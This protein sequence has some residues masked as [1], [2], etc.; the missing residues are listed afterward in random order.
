MALIDVKQKPLD[1]K[2][3]EVKSPID[4][5]ID[6]EPIDEKGLADI[7]SESNDLAADQELIMDTMRLIESD[8][9]KDQKKGI[10]T[11]INDS[12]A[13]IPEQMQ[14]GAQIAIKNSIQ[15]ISDV[16]DLVGDLSGTDFKINEK[17][18]KFL[19]QF[20]EV[21][22][23]AKGAVK[24]AQT[25]KAPVIPKA[26][27]KAG[28]IA[29]TAAQ[30]A[31][32]FFPAMRVVK[33][34]S[35]V[36][37]IGKFLQTAFAGGLAAF[38]A[39]DPDT[40]KFTE[41]FEALHP[42]LKVPF[43][44]YLRGEQDDSNVEKRFKNSI[45]DAIGFGALGSLFFGIGKIL[46]NAG[47]IGRK[48]GGIKKET[49]IT[50]AKDV[51]NEISK[52][53]EV[54]ESV[55]KAAS[56]RRVVKEV[57]TQ[58]P[59]V[60]LEQLKKTNPEFINNI[61][62]E[63]GTVTI[64][65][66]VGKDKT[67]TLRSGDFVTTNKDAAKRF[68]IQGTI[69]KQNVPIENLRIATGAKAR[70]NEM[71]FV[72]RE[73]P[74]K[75]SER[76][77]LAL[78]EFKGK[79]ALIAQ[80]KKTD[81][82]HLTKREVDFVI[83]NKDKFDEKILKRIEVIEPVKERR[84][85][86]RRGKEQ[87]G[88]L[89]TAQFMKQGKLNAQITIQDLK[90]TQKKFNAHAAAKEGN[91]TKSGKLISQAAKGEP[92]PKGFDPVSKKQF[93]DLQ[94]ISEKDVALT[95]IE[96]NIKTDNFHVEADIQT[97][98]NK[99]ATLFKDDVKAAKG[100]IPLTR[101][102]IKVLAEEHGLSVKDIV[103]MNAGQ[104][105]FPHQIK[106]FKFHIAQS[107]E[108]IDKLT[109]AFQGGDK[110]VS[111]ELRKEIALAGHLIPKF[112]SIGT[113]SSNMLREFKL[114]P[115]LNLKLIKQVGNTLE[116]LPVGANMEQLVEAL[117]TLP[118]TLKAKNIFT[119]TMSTGSD[120][121]REAW[122]A[123]MVA[124]TKTLL[125]VNPLGNL[126]LLMFGFQERAIA[127]G[128][129]MVFTGGK[130]GVA[131][132]EAQYLAYGMINSVR[133]AAEVAGKT[134]KSGIQ[135]PQF[136]KFAIPKA[137]SSENVNLSS[138]KNEVAQNYLKKGIDALG[139]TI[140]TP[141]NVLG[142]TD[143]FFKVL[144]TRGHLYSLGARKAFK[145]GLTPESDDFIKAVAEVVNNPT[146]ALKKEAIDFGHY[147][148]FTNELN[149]DRGFIEAAGAQITE[150]ANEHL[151]AKII[152]PFSRIA[153]NITKYTLEHTPMA[154][155]MHDF[156]MSMKA[157]GSQKQLAFAKIALGSMYGGLFAYLASAGLISGNYPTGSLTQSRL[158]T[159]AGFPKNAFNI[160]G[161]A[162]PFRRVDVIGSHMAAAAD[163]VEMSETLDNDSLGELATGL[164]VMISD[165]IL[166]KSYLTGVADVMEVLLG[167]KNASTV[168][169]RFAGTLFPFSSAVRELAR[170]IDPTER[171]INPNAGIW[172]SFR[173]GFIKGKP[174]LKDLYL[175]PKR[176]FFGEVIKRERYFDTMNQQ[177]NP[178]LN[179]LIEFEAKVAFKPSRFIAGS[180]QARLR[181][182]TS[183]DG[184]ELSNE[185][186][187]KLRENFGI[188]EIGGLVVREAIEQIITQPV[189]KNASKA[190]KAGILE[191]IVHTYRS[192]AEEKLKQ[193]DD[194]LD[195]LINLK[196]LLK[197]QE[198]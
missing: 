138:I 162:H 87:V 127:R 196:L 146:P 36:P 106:S 142:A 122:I 159:E 34:V 143:D 74:P 151:L 82:K 55:I 49:K 18:E 56:E 148:T 22:V 141:F 182:P 17:V 198:E 190:Q 156:N 67:R 105:I 2:P 174:F 131:P 71:F 10:L 16:I 72:P 169:Q 13:E 14:G 158:K 113:T 154:F 194:E 136:S 81:P 51:A 35:A 73:V 9:P 172:E 15:A 155:L 132:H 108:K 45:D 195:E 93:K 123:G 28:E 164:S 42:K 175:L 53:I 33:G 78:A 176:G 128:I 98:Y 144:N 157:G 129:S 181:P 165:N 161:K 94:G 104:P 145:N 193:D 84:L 187:D 121:F 96:L 57:A 76:R 38:A 116:E 184:I 112:E 90:N 92:L 44:S 75:N 80:I 20:N 153:T 197:A 110:S 119:R 48:I 91:F 107:L 103:E 68:D 167:K 125:A 85:R 65:R 52:K 40:P 183:A 32:G 61:L 168:L 109:K 95:D 7:L 24:A 25:G 79:E 177:D 179:A 3:L 50:N 19:E 29:K 117:S 21:D 66:N 60:P 140:R 152:A 191:S 26:E 133:E 89:E 160:G 4:T 97:S 111:T 41:L 5:S 188:I 86:Q 130:K 185:Q 171:E 115:D 69:I 135:D 120:M 31:I 6:T 47:A 99:V 58:K 149:K 88:T 101:E 102:K 166:S 126:N 62:K 12:L 1:T 8:E 150:F 139:W 70:N 134:L 118:K 137:L 170:A 59:S 46:K 43:A 114:D 39:L 64:F 83:E 77:L 63:D 180:K 100:D 27:T 124:G 37:K 178:A 147:Q 192:V 173:D 23:S 30:Y 54:E 11:S 186:Y 163:I 189:F